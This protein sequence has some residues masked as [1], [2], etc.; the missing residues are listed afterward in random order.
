MAIEEAF[1]KGPELVLPRTPEARQMGEFIAA[2][3]VGS[4]NQFEAD[5]QFDII[6]RRWNRQK[7]FG[8]PQASE[9]YPMWSAHL[10]RFNTNDD[11]LTTNRTGMIEVR[12]TIPEDPLRRIVELPIIY[13]IDPSAVRFVN[14]SYTATIGDSGFLLQS[15]TNGEGPIYRGFYFA[16]GIMCSFMPEEVDEETMRALKGEKP[17]FFSQ[18][19]FIKIAREAD[20]DSKFKVIELTP[21]LDGLTTDYVVLDSVNQ[22]VPRKKEY[23]LDPKKWNVDLGIIG[24]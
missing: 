18:L 16:N 2:M 20:S 11:R 10:L 17:N 1:T 12:R 15:P 3:S 6:P 23:P 22:L 13:C 4:Y 8:G 24:F 19:P 14:R 7:Y 5:G 21:I 9:E